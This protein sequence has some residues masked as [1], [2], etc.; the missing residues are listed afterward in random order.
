[1]QMRSLQHDL[2]KA[3]ASVLSRFTARWRNRTL[4]RSWDSWVGLCISAS[5]MEHSAKLFDSSVRRMCKRRLSLA[6]H[7]WLARV[8]KQ[9]E[10]YLLAAVNSPL[11]RV[12]LVMVATSRGWCTRMLAKCVRT[13]HARVLELQQQEHFMLRMAT[14]MQHRSMALAWRSWQILIR[15]QREAALRE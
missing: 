1:M 11:R 9:R 6:W 3:G 8:Q 4:L 15:Q 10:Q 13:W 7:S 2:E 5:D 14:R 12:Q